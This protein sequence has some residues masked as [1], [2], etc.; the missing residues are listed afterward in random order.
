MSWFS[1]VAWKEGLFLQ[2]QHLQQADR[3]HEHLV[4]ARTRLIT[5]Y[6]WGVGELVLDRDQAQ[7]G[8]IA[9]RAVT[10]LQVRC[11]RCA[12]GWWCPARSPPG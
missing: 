10:L 7:Q 3:Y 12:A 8:M 1:K 2:P 9:L 5:P 11:R 4:N 6:P